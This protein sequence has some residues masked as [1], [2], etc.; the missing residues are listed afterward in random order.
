MGQQLP[1]ADLMIVKDVLM[2]L[3]N[4]AIEQ[5]LEGTINCPEPLYKAV[6]LVQ[7][8]FEDPHEG[9]KRARGGDIEPGQRLPFGISAAPFY[10]PF[11]EVFK[12]ESD[13]PK[14]V[15]LWEAERCPCHRGG[16]AEA[17][18]EAFQ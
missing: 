8:C 4:R 12:W 6:L 15:Q 11:A 1:A 7:N 16:V 9:T 2:H 10:A 5:F 3:P 13:E 14:A 18:A 17:G